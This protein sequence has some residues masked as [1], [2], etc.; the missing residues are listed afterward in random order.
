MSNGEMSDAS[1]LTPAGARDLPAGRRQI[2]KEHL[3]TEFRL[4][5]ATQAAP[6]PRPGRGRPRRRTALVLA[7]GAGVV[8]AAV[9][10]AVVLVPGHQAAGGH[11]TGGGHTAANGTTSPGA[12]LLAKIADAAGRQPALQAGDS[13][14]MYIRSEVAY[15]VDT[16]SGGHETSTMQRP[17]ERQ[18]WLPAANIC[19]PGLL[20]EGG[21]RT[22][23]GGSAGSATGL[24]PSPKSSPEASPPQSTGCGEGSV[25]DA[26]YRLLQSLPTDPQALLRLIY[27]QTKGE[28]PS[29]DAEAF[30]TIGDLMRE[31]IVPPGTAAALYRAAALIPGVTVVGH[32]TD[33]AGR[34]GVAV[35]WTVGQDRD[36][37]IFNPATGQFLGERDY[38]TATGAVFGEST[39]LQRA[40]TARAGQLP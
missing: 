25:G 4:A 16:I 11:A 10:A 34:P 18:V 23:L 40:F 15:T 3:M 32:A 20:I 38:N 7:T 14:F 36:E 31:T 33:A 12:T 39:V 37:W 17:H 28:G 5:S 27:A 19:V 30:T 22:T 24:A 26:T 6:P 13:G 2:L 35:A 9:A 8:A 1:R 29:P 21:S